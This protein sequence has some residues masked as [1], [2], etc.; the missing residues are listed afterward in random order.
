MTTKSIGW[1]IL[2]PGAI[3]QKFAA[4]LR[5]VPDADLVAVGS[6]SQTR[7]ETFAETYGVKRA[8]AGYEALMNDPDVDV[9]YIAT[10][11]PFHHAQTL[12][13]L[14]HGKAVLCEKP[15]AV[16]AQQAQEMIAC[17]QEEDLFL[18]EAM[19][20]RFL[21]VISE[22]RTWLKEGRIGDAR[23]LSADFGFRG[24]WRPKERWLNPELAGG[25]LLDVGVYTVALSQ[26][27]FREA[28]TEIAVVAHIG[29]SHVDEQT[30]MALRY[31]GGAL[32]QLSCA[33]RT[34]TPGTAVISGTQ[35][36]IHIPHFWEAQSATLEVQGEPIV[37][38]TGKSGYHYQAI[39]VMRC[40]REGLVESPRMSLDESLT[41][42]SI[43]DQARE[44][45]G[46]QYPIE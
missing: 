23:M 7:A 18:M 40:L 21:P 20:T 30:A 1:G 31:P 25:A 28:P 36:I 9:I 19:W 39:E 27:I 41:I 34:D 38:I 12:D 5:Q 6:R 35:G 29:E 15:L 16:N 8:Y 32:A 17:A 2:G 26:M 11:H 3:A 42:A 37:E 22:I 45:I 33:V 44:R 13:C 4:D 14:H 24:A 43:M 46:L 10:P